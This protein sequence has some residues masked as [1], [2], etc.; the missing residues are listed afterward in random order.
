MTKGVWRDG[1]VYSRIHRQSFDHNQDHGTGKVC[2]PSVQEHIVFLTWFDVHQTTV[3]EPQL[4]LLD[5]SW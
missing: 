2:T 5:G 1:F 4:Q 3:V